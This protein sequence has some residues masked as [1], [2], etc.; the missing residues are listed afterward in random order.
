[1]MSVP[2]R[3]HMYELTLGLS[4]V[5]GEGVYEKTDSMEIA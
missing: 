5:D 3:K 1:M 4:E 2:N